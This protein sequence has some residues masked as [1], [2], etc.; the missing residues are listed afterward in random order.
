MGISLIMVLMHPQ[1]ING[2]EIEQDSEIEK[3]VV[4]LDS[5][6]VNED[7]VVSVDE[8]FQAADGNEYRITMTGLK[9]DNK[10][11]FIQCLSEHYNP[12][13]VTELKIVDDAF[14]DAEKWNCHQE[15]EWWNEYDDAHCWAAAT[16]NMIWISGW[17][18]QMINPD[19]GASFTSEDEVFEYVSK[20]FSDKGGDIDVGIEWFFT[21]EMFPKGAKPSTG[22]LNNDD[23]SDGLLPQIYPDTILNTYD[24]T[25]DTSFIEQLLRLSME[26]KRPITAGGHIG[27]LGSG[28]LDSPLHAITIAGII[29]DP[30]AGSLENQVKGIVLIDSDNDAIVS[31]TEKEN[32]PEFGPDDVFDAVKRA[33]RRAYRAEVKKSRTNSYTVYNL[34][35]RMDAEGTPYWEIEGYSEYPNALYSF[36]TLE[37]PNEENIRENL[38][39]EGTTDIFTDVDLSLDYLFA[40]D[41]DETISDPFD[42]M[43]D[44]IKKEEFESGS[45]VNLLYFLANR[46]RVIFDDQYPSGNKVLIEW[47]VTRDCDG[48]VVSS[49][50]EI[51][52][53][54]IYNGTYEP[55]L[56]ELNKN[57]EKWCSGTYTI[58]IN[59]NTDKAVTESYYKNNHESS[60]KITVTGNDCIDDKTEEKI[61]ENTFHE[62]VYVQKGVPTGVSNHFTMWILLMLT[63]CW[64]IVKTQKE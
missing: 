14:N 35:Y 12:N 3:V 57:N 19:T 6:S 37:L 51:K 20:R 48:T 10:E 64:I 49:G 21:G 62:P 1:I 55:D 32:D 11:D 4:D 34:K 53:F 31:E 52:E 5:S 7:P 63:S 44:E 58:T 25:D 2:E 39:T 40:T 38:E 18:K 17:G 29:T 16:S 33:E 9:E 60:I 22:L 8:Q 47:T 61:V 36:V 27:E 42:F 41:I 43:I 15:Q 56:L 30:A 26:S 54:T 13:T 59:F 24:L 23:T 50:S 28:I 45:P 46:S